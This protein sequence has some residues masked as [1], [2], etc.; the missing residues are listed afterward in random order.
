MLKKVLWIITVAFVL[1]VFIIDIPYSK[2]K[3]TKRKK[4]IS[5][6]IEKVTSSKIV[7][8]SGNIYKIEDDGSIMFYLGRFDGIKPGDVL[9]IWRRK[10]NIGKLRVKETEGYFSRGNLI[11]VKEDAEI[12]I[13]DIVS[14]IP[15]YVYE[16]AT[17]EVT[18]PTVVQEKKQ[19]IK[20]V[21]EGK[22]PEREIKQERAKEKTEKKEETKEMP[23]AITGKIYVVYGSDVEIN[24]GKEQNIPDDAILDVVRGNKKIGKI[25]ITSAKLFSSSAKIISVEPGENIL[26]GDSVVYYFKK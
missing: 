3:K 8:I 16:Y 14:N 1:I 17:E 23:S 24:I 15:V 19:E 22:L 26:R 5:K 9:N 21:N 11:F 20:T 18:T 6:K 7:E 4:A 2:T 13:G 12:K 10:E 25:Q